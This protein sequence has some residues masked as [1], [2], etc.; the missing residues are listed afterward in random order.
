MAGKS[1]EPLFEAFQVNRLEIRVSA[2]N[3][4][5]EMVATKCGFNLEGTHREAAYS[6]GQLYDMRSYALLRREW[7]AN[8]KMQ[9]TA[10]GV[11]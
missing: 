4:E 7:A 8:Q 1:P 6:K 3:D 9:P 11:G 10:E 2:G 5:S